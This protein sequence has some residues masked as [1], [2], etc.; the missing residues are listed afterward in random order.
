MAMEKGRRYQ[1]VSL[2]TTQTL[3]LRGEAVA[4]SLASSTESAQLLPLLE[5]AAIVAVGATG[6]GCA[7]AIKVAHFRSVAN[8]EAKKRLRIKSSRGV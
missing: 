8:K 5:A 4:A 6:K 1:S 3:N 7:A 2:Q